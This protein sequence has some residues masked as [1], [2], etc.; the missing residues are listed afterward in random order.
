MARG[1]VRWA[2]KV[3]E[4][5]TWFARVELDGE[6]TTDLAKT[7]YDAAGYSPPFWQLPK[8]RRSYSG[9]VT[10][11]MKRVC[12]DFS[13][14]VAS[15]GFRKTGRRLWTRVTEWSIESIY[16]HRSGSSYG[17]PCNADVSIRV[18]LAVRVLND[19]APGGSIGIDSDYVRRE[20]GYC[21]HHRFNVVTWSTYDRCVDELAL[22]VTEFAEPW[23]A[24][25]RDPQKL[26]AHPELRLSTKKLLEEAVAGHANPE[27]VA[28]S[29][30]AFGVKERH[31]K[32]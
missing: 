2:E 25:W 26:M 5:E 7:E 24:E 17:A 22:Y 28:A 20:N 3:G 15:F 9:V 12:E 29:L 19:P 1:L 10:Q 14:R 13:G 8:M 21:Y 18:M 30:K 32:V 31:P 27:S 11:G 23:F 16:F 6:Q 4:T